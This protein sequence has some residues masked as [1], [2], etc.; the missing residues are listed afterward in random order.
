MELARFGI[1]RLIS[2]YTIVG[3]DR[4]AGGILVF[5]IV[6]GFTALWYLAER[7]FYQRVRRMIWIL[8]KSWQHWLFGDNPRLS[9]KAR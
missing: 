3:M 5:L 2:G 8:P 4:V 1:S 9:D 6:L 7:H